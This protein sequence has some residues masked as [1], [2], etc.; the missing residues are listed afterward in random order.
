M[1]KVLI[2]LSLTIIASIFI[3]ACTIDDD[4]NPV[5]CEVMFQDLQDLSIAIEDY[6]AASICKDEFECRYIAY[7]SKPCGGPWSYLIYSTSIDTLELQTLVAD[8]NESEN[9]YN[10]TCGAVSDCSVPQP[11]TGFTCE[12]NLCIPAF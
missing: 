2:Y 4:D 9:N 5:T 6:A 12:D 3:I 1:K 10:I 7:G 8:Y 11:P